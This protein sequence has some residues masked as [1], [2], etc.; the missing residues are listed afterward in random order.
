MGAAGSMSTSA[1]PRR[2]EEL[3]T[4]IPIFPLPNV[5]LLPRGKL[6][7]NVFEPRYLE[8]V[9]DAIASHRLI[10]MVQPKN[11]KA[12]PDHPEVYQTGCAGRIT[13][14]AETED[15]RYLITLS[16]VSRFDIVRELPIGEKLHRRVEVSYGRFADDLSEPNEPGLDRARLTP[17][18][19]GYFTLHGLTADWETIERTPDHHLITCLAMICPFK[20]NEKQALLEC[21]TTT[22]RADTMITLIEMALHEGRG[23]RKPTRLRQ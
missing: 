7:L 19:K 3:P 11:P 16:G 5:L 4:T 1:N 6:P 20:P 23:S 14:F 15:G 13:S 8:M 9:Q 2:I 21:P 10:G 12:A 17:A 18:L 22:A